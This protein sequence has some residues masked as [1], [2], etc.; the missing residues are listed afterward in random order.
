MGWNDGPYNIA[1]FMN[2]QSHY[3]SPVEGAPPNVNFQCTT[4]GGSVGGG[5]YPCAISNFTNYEPDF[6]TFDLSFGY[7]TGDIP[8]N[9][10]LKNLTLQ[11]TVQNLLNRHSP[12]DYIPTTAGGRQVTAYDLTRPNSGRTIGITLVKNW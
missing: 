4:S 3:F 7:N 2:F 9:V 12:F 5:T 10:Y 6:I 1:G 8:A 11:F